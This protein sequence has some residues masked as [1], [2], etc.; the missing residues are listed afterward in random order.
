MDSCRFHSLYVGVIL[1]ALL[2]FAGFF[3]LN[4]FKKIFQDT[5]RMIQKIVEFGLGPNYLQKLSVEDTSTLF[6]E[7]KYE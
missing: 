3:K 7:L 5:I 6:K 2:L 1:H 4:I